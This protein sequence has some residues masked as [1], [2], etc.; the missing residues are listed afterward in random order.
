MFIPRIPV[1]PS[2]FPIEFK[3]VQF[4]VKLSFA[5]SVNKS[6]GQSYKVVGLDLQTPC[7]SHGQFYVGASRVGSRENLYVYAPNGITNVVYQEV[8]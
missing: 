2:D 1:L 6:Q 8:L 3:R 7:F 4:P 5:M